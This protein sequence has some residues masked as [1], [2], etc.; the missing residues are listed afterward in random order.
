[1]CDE[2]RAF[3]RRCHAKALRWQRL[4]R[5]ARFRR[6]LVVTLRWRRNSAHSAWGVGHLMIG[7]GALAPARLDLLARTTR[8]LPNPML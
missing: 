7:S 8:L 4:R 1:M 6:G 3:A 2:A 5:W